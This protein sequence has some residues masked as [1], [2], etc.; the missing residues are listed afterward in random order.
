MNAHGTRRVESPSVSCRCPGPHTEP[1]CGA[2]TTVRQTFARLPLVLDSQMPGL[3][4]VAERH[5]VLQRDRL[6]N[7]R[8]AGGVG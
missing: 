6:H 8:A 1:V 2:Q 5:E 4:L 3:L 7:P